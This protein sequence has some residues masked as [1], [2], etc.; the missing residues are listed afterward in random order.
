MKKKQNNPANKTTIL[1]ILN[2]A[3]ADILIT[4]YFKIPVR[5]SKHLSLH[6]LYISDQKEIHDD[7]VENQ[8]KA[9]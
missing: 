3:A 1:N 5:F 7:L 2:H 9:G 4:D 6:K 8:K